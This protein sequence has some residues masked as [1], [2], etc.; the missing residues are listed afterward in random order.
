MVILRDHVIHFPL[1]AII[2]LC[3]NSKH[4]SLFHLIYNL[5][6]RMGLRLG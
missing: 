5:T 6:V 2:L 3:T 1:V 4:S